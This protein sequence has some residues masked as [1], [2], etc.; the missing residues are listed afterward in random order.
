MDD[1]LGLGFADL[2][3][4]PH[5]FCRNPTKTWENWRHSVGIRSMLIHVHVYT[6][7]H[8][9]PI[10]V[11]A[12]SQP[13]TIR[14][15]NNPWLVPGIHSPFAQPLN[16]KSNQS[17]W[18]KK[19]R[20]QKWGKEIWAKEKGSLYFHPR[21]W[22]AAPW[23]Q[24]VAWMVKFKTQE[25]E[26]QVSTST[27]VNRPKSKVPP[28]R[29]LPRSKYSSSLCVCTSWEAS[30]FHQNRYHSWRKLEEIRYKWSSS[31]HFHVF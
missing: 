14:A 29:S 18:P 27:R 4:Q 3:M 22:N 21:F 28:F 1:E 10:K 31:M 12:N 11:L 7:N 5:H 20:R 13:S 15:G 6:W 23:S 9:L 17:A 2:I 19:R 30:Q 25:A 16:I 26:D 8:F 24:N